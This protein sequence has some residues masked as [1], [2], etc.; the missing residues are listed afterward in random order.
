MRLPSNQT[1]PESGLSRPTMCLRSTLFPVPLAPTRTSQQKSENPFDAIK[2]HVRLL[3][4]F[5]ENEILHDDYEK[6]RDEA[7][8][9]GAADAAGAR[10]AVKS[11]VATDQPDRSAEEDALEQPLHDLPH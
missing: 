11:F 5:R 7:L 2:R 10:P 6:A 1:S 8:G 9:A 3:G 4:D